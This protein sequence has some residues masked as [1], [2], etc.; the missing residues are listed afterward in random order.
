MQSAYHKLPTVNGAMQQAGRRFKASD[1]QYEST[2]AFAEL[3]QD[4]SGAYPESAGIESWN[5]AIRLN[6]QDG[7]TLSDDYT[8]SSGG[9]VSFSFM[10][11][12]QPTI[13]DAGI[14]VSGTPHETEKQ[15]DF[16]IVYNTSQVTPTIEAISVE[17]RQLKRNWGDTMYRI[18]FTHRNQTLS[19]RVVFNISK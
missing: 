7:V 2:D 1:V 11:P 6:R 13:S 9:D 19:D 3:R 8:L 5:R 15:I 18:L 10:T 16:T 4:I 12:Y 14:T 17:D